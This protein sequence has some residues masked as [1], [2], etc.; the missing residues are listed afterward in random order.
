[1]APCPWEAHSLGGWQFSELS[2]EVGETLML[3]EHKA[4]TEL[5]WM[6]K[7]QGEEMIFKLR[8]EG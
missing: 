5:S 8:P 2:T 1:M 4:D 3:R 7:D 6:V